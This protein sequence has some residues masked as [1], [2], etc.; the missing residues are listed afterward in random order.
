MKNKKLTAIKEFAENLGLVVTETL[1]SDEDQFYTHRLAIKRVHQEGQSVLAFSNN[2]ESIHI[3]SYKLGDK[4]KWSTNIYRYTFIQAKG[5][6]IQQKR[7][8]FWLTLMAGD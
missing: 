2:C 4:S 8:N 3:G 7:I 5:Q 6:H 1:T